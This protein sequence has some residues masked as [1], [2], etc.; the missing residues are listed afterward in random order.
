MIDEGSFANSRSSSDNR[1]VTVV[2]R[3]RN[4]E[5][6]SLSSQCQRLE[7]VKAF[8]KWLTKENHILTNPASE[9]VQLRQ[10]QANRAPNQGQPILTTNSF[11]LH[12]DK[13]VQVTPRQSETLVLCAHG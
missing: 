12:I 2:Y 6:L 13:R 11:A 7:P 5:P 4:G 3:K 10:P 9:L 1:T 8:F